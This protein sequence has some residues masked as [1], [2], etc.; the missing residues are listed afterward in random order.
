MNT[1]FSKEQ[2]ETISKAMHELMDVMMNL[3]ET[4]T[5]E[6]IQ[7]AS[8]LNLAISTLYKLLRK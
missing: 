6:N 8:E 7:T 4:E 3:I 2:K 5:Q 1:T